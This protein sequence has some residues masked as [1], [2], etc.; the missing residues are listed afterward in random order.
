M[1]LEELYM[2]PQ[3]FHRR[4]H[5]SLVLHILYRLDGG[6]KQNVESVYL[7]VVQGA[8]LGRDTHE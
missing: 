4:L 1:L 2:S 6:L 8:G 3:K 7:L 5:D